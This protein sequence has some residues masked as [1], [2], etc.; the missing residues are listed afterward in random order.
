MPNYCCLSVTLEA[1]RIVLKTR[2]G[3]TAFVGV[4]NIDRQVNIVNSKLKETDRLSDDLVM[5]LV[6]RRG[7]H[8]RVR[9]HLVWHSLPTVAFLLRLHATDSFSTAASF[10]CVW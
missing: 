1:L 8:L 2:K 5:A 7:A 10:D 6:D 9:P 3:C 4:F